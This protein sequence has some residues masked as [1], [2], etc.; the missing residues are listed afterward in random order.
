MNRS[1]FFI[2]RL[3]AG[4]IYPVCSSLDW[5]DVVMAQSLFLFS[6]KING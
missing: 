2:V 4:F 5:I 6:L 3:N 1:D